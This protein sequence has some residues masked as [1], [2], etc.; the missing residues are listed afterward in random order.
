[1]LFDTIMKR[2]E[3]WLGHIIR[4]TIHSWMHIGRERR[5]RRM[6][7]LIMIDDVKREG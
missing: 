1:M 6:R 3:N 7:R 4:G 2:K 5:R